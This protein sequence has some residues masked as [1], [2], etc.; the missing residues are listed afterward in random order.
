MVVLGIVRET[1]PL[2]TQPLLPGLSRLGSSGRITDGPRGTSSYFG[3]VDKGSWRIAAEGT[4][5]GP[6]VTL[7]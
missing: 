1:E 7:T 2:F 4:I 3:D 5:E 6:D